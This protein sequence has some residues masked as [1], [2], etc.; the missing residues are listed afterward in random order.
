LTSTLKTPNANIILLLALSSII[1]GLIACENPGSVGD[2]FSDQN[3]RIVQDTLTFS[4]LDSVNVSSQSGDKPFATAGI[5]TDQLFGKH[6]SVAL[7]QPGI[8][9]IPVD[10]L[11]E[12][13]RVTT[14]NLQL[15]IDQSNI[16]GDTLS[17]VDFEL[18]EIA[19]RWDDEDWRFGDTPML[20]TNIVGE[21]SYQ[22]GDTV[23]VSLKSDWVKRY[24]E[25]F[26][27]EAEMRDSTFAQEIFGFAVV[28]QNSGK[29]LPIDISE[30]RLHINTTTT[31]NEFNQIM[32]QSAT[33]LVRDQS[34]VL[35]DNNFEL[36]STLNNSVS[37][38]VDSILNKLNSP[39]ISASFITIKQNDSLLAAS[40][41]T[42]HIRP[43]L[44]ETRLF[45]STA[46]SIEDLLI[47]GDRIGTVIPESPTADRLELNITNNLEQFII[48]QDSLVSMYFVYGSGNGLIRSSLYHGVDSKMLPPTI[49]VT[50]LDP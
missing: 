41:P 33:S 7:I 4:T 5:Y 10:T 20:T 6:E 17:T 11:A 16:W 36:S 15:I 50:S 26:N 34:P 3:S 29:L 18:I 44:N 48:N 47:T 27:M 45:F 42:N 12:D 23:D 24:I 28:P 39:V 1:A 40:L 14:M 37:I 25:I 30:T 49:F 8:G 31:A 13:I 22:Q 38:S 43:P 35:D 19:E 32:D 9:N 46:E 21:F 2:Q